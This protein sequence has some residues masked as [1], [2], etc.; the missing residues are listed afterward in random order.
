MTEAA[1]SETSIANR[2][3]QRLGA[4]R[5]E[6]LDQNTPNA[7]SAAAAYYPIR[8]RLLRQHAWNF[9][10]KRASI[11][12]DVDATTW[13]SL[14]QY[15]KPNDFIRLLRDTVSGTPDVNTRK[16]W[17]IE[18]NYIVTADGSPLQFRYV[19]KITDPALFDPLFAE[20]LAIDMAYEMCE[21]ITQ[22]TAK[23][24]GLREDR[25]EI[26]AEARRINAFENEPQREPEDD[27]ILA[28]L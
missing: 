14:K 7:R 17:Q 11:A 20:L 27:W 18:G 13:G 24:E 3:L 8:N 9:A 2:A 28:M 23:R 15:Q 26:I 25:K 1:I 5:V 4:K 12:A 21:E 6:S 10:I 16:D 22:S 19:A